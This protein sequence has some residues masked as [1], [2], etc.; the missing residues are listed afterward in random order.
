M[1]LADS[2]TKRSMLTGLSAGERLFVRIQSGRWDTT[3]T[4]LLFM[5][6]CLLTLIKVYGFN[7]VPDFGDF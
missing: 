6:I 4:Q 5:H 2:L 7:I 3:W 1:K